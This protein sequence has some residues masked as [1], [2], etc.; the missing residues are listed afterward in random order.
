MLNASRV[1]LVP[2]PD[3]RIPQMWVCSLRELGGRIGQARP[4]LVVSI[5]DPASPHE[6]AQAERALSTCPRTP[7][8]RL[9][10]H[11]IQDSEEGAEAPGRGHMAGLFAWLARQAPPAT[12]LVHCHAGLSR[13][14]AIALA[15]AAFLARQS[16][17]ADVRLADELAE[18]V[19]D[20]APICLPNAA[21]VALADNMLGF[22]GQLSSSLSRMLSL[23][24]SDPCG[25]IW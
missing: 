3:F 21:I 6:E 7:V 23:R 16:R 10:F 4:D 2:P 18:A 25:S 1:S 5:C 12:L 9:R 20:A 22:D 11:D 24:R 14:P 17:P 13:S 15:A 8:M 19:L